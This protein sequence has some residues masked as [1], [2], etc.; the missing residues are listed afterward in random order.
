MEETDLIGQLE[1]LIK[2][3]SI[4]Q[5]RHDYPKEY[6]MLDGETQGF[7]PSPEIIKES[8]IIPP[9]CD[10]EDLA[11][12]TYGG[13]VGEGGNEAK[14]IVETTT[15]VSHNR[16]VAYFTL[17][18]GSWKYQLAKSLRE[19]AKEHICVSDTESFKAWEKSQL[20]YFI[21]KNMGL[22]S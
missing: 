6:A 9:S 20:R 10:A 13:S 14:L 12:R 19:F 8:M 11:I 1:N 22:K 17:E 3:F 4:A 7:L 18:D 15:P 5:M 21:R 2:E 16:S